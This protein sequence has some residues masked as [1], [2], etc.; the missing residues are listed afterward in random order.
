MELTGNIFVSDKTRLTR[1]TFVQVIALKWQMFNTNY[2]IRQRNEN[3]GKEN[4]KSM[5]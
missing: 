2:C 5:Y 1:P 4:Y 3:K